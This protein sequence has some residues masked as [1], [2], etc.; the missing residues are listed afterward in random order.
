MQRLSAVD[1][2]SP[3]FAHTKRQLFGPFRLD[4][5]A[6]LGMV[7]LLTGEFAGGSGSGSTL[8][9]PA[10]GAGTGGQDFLWQAEPVWQQ[11]LRY[12]P[13]V[14]FGVVVLVAL[15][16]V[17]IYIASVFRFVLFDAVLTGRAHLAQGWRRWQEAG[18]SF[19][20]WQLTFGL[21][22]ILLMAVAVD[23]WGYSSPAGSASCCCFSESCYWGHSSTSWPRISW[24]P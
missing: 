8:N 16:V 10:G 17:A 4:F 11:V 2:I 6:R 22:L 24:C 14:V 13:W 3:A 1:A 5:W 9:I 12:L 21:A 15:G 23:T 7:S 19:F 20:L 18:G